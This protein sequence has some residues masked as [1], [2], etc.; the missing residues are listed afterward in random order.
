M[1]GETC[2]PAVAG[3]VAKVRVAGKHVVH[4]QAV[5]SA[6]DAVATPMP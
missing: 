5:V 6:V 2:G 4:D 3:D 1:A